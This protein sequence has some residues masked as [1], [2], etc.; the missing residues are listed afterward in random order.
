[1]VSITDRVR[2]SETDLMAVVHHTNYLR[3]FEMGR[4]AW[5]RQAGIDLNGLHDAGFMVPIVEVQCKYRQSARFDDVYEIQTTLKACSR[6]MIQFSY[7][8]LRKADGVLLAE[9]TSKNAFVNL[10]GKV[11]RL[12]PD[13]Y[14][15]LQQLAA[16][17][18]EIQP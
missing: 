17:E 18:R 8:I 7:R 16:Q 9:G 2:F 13:Y 6:V 3:W 10:E 4:V 1:M 15:K 12:T 5:F 11:T 14:E